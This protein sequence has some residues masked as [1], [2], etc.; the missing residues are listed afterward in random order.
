M[1]RVDEPRAAPG[2]AGPLLV[3]GRV[4][5]PHALRGE[6]SVVVVGDDPGRL[7]PGREVWVEPAGGAP[8]ARALRVVESRPQRDRLLVR[9]AGIASRE[10]AERLAG[11][12]LSVPFDPAG[13]AAGEYYP[14]QLEGLRVRT[15]T[16]ELVGTV[17][18]VLFLPGRPLLEVDSGR[19]ATRLVP[20]HPEFVREVDLAGGALTIDP[21]EG[22]LEL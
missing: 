5:R 11:G 4:A 1:A 14:N 20:F 10:D 17:A 15:T 6:V 12:D 3:V 8:G 21:P 19:G 16:G 7:A 18:R 13:L 9:F 22:L 2:A